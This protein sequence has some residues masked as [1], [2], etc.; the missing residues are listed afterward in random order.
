MRIVFRVDASLK[1]G[2]GHVVRCLTLA[3]E[4]AKRGAEVEFVC[5]KLPGNQC[6]L[7]Q[8]K[9]YKLHCLALTNQENDDYCFHADW[10]EAHWQEDATQTL[11]YARD[12]DW[13]IVDHY[14]LDEK[15]E[16]IIHPHVGRIMV[17]DDLADRKHVCDLLLDQNHYNNF[18]IRYKKLAPDDCQFLLMPKYALLREE[19]VFA[20]AKL[21]RSYDGVKKILIFF[22]GVDADNHTGKTLKA[23]EDFFKGE[24]T[25]I[26]G[27]ANENLAELQD[28]CKK[29]KN[30]RL[31][32]EVGNMAQ[33][34]TEADLGIGAGGSTSWERAAMGLPTLAWPIAQNQ[35]KI[36]NDLSE[37]GMVKLSSPKTLVADIKHMIPPV[38][39]EM[40]AKAMEI[41][42]GQGATRVANKI[43]SL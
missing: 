26:A 2:S 14:A 10:L 18:D 6:A 19:F 20:K 30:W 25:V 9:K 1:I 23:L 8:S 17:I 32:K 7:I 29:H 28:L 41:C 11:L 43:W 22:G 31:L 38:L 12:A 36:L 24:I 33:L 4:L 27:A 35:V 16:E 21:K 42:D 34:M 37:A 39:R 13:L 5:R 3:H 15:W 40:S